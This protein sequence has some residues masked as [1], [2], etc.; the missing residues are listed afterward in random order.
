MWNFK[1]H[2]IELVSVKNSF[3]YHREPYCPGLNK[4][5]CLFVIGKHIHLFQPCRLPAGG[6]AGTARARLWG[7]G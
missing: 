5:K 7:E 4:E 1:G 6:A 2:D 3:G